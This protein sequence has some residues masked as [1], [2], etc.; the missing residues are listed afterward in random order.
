MGVRR[1][2][3]R[4]KGLTWIESVCITDE[5]SPNCNAYSGNE[6]TRYTIAYAGNES[7][8]YC[9]GRHGHLHRAISIATVVGGLRRRDRRYYSKQRLY[10]WWA[11]FY[12]KLPKQGWYKRVDFPGIANHGL[13]K[14]L[15]SYTHFPFCSRSPHQLITNLTSGLEQYFSTPVVLASCL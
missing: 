15:T 11:G 6:A 9:N 14:T 12:R 10:Y 2:Q 7:P 8:K 4:V 13:R 3:C 1:G 5:T